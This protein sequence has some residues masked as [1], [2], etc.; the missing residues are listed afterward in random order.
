MSFPLLQPWAIAAGSCAY[1]LYIEKAHVT[2]TE[3][4]PP[5]W[6]PQSHVAEWQRKVEIVRSRGVIL[7]PVHGFVHRTP[8]DRLRIGPIRS[9]ISP[10]GNFAGAELRIVGPELEDPPNELCEALLDLT[11]SELLNEPTE[12]FIK[13]Y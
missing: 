6:L 1:N 4:W 5:T 8:E 12:V 3:W 2:F 10:S 7:D 11:G 9:R 13:K